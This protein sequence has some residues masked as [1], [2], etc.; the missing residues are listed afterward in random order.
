VSAED[1]RYYIPET[2]DSKKVWKTIGKYCNQFDTPSS[3]I[4][5]GAFLNICLEIPSDTFTEE[6][7]EDFVTHSNTDLDR[8]LDICMT[9]Y[10][11]NLV[12]ILLEAG[13]I[14]EVKDNE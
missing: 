1:K 9:Y 4:S 10:K 5:L 8:S 3:G 14:K 7:L 11:K 12:D 6:D 13:A 2:G